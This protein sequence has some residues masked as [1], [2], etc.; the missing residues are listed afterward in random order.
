[1]RSSR[2]SSKLARATFVSFSSIFLDVPLAFDP[3]AMFCTP[4]R[5]ACT[6]WS[7]VRL[8]RSTYR[9]QK[10]AVTS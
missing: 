9:S 3:S 4:L 1:V 5:A 7:W 2:S 8:R 6:I 10:R